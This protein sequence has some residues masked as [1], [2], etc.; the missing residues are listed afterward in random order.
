MSLVLMLIGIPFLLIHYYNGRGFDEIIPI[1]SI[2]VLVW[3]IDIIV[4]INVM[5]RAIR[6]VNAS[7]IK[8]D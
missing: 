6:G 5:S 2:V 8:K 4:N 1:A 7:K 3:M